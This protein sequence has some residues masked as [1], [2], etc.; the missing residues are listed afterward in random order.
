[1]VIVACL[2]SL[3][4]GVVGALTGGGS[5][6][7][8]ATMSMWLLGSIGLL[9]FAQPKRGPFNHDAASIRPR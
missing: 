2:A 1:V 6:F 4:F 5:Q 8:F 9:R 3:A 7:R